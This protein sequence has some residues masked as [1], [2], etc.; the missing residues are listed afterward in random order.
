MNDQ[1]YFFPINRP[2]EKAFSQSK[3]NPAKLPSTHIN[4]KKIISNYDEGPSIKEKSDFSLYSFTTNNE[5]PQKPSVKK[6]L[7]EKNHSPSFETTNRNEF[8]K[9]EIRVKIKAVKE[10]YYSLSGKCSEITKSIESL[11]KKARD[12]K[13]HNGK[14]KIEENVELKAKMKSMENEIRTWKKKFE[15]TEKQNFHEI[16]QMKLLFRNSFIS[17]ESDI[18]EEKSAKEKDETK[19]SIISELKEKI[20][21]MIKKNMELNKMLNRL[22]DELGFLKI[23]SQAA[24][25]D[26]LSKILMKIKKERAET[27]KGYLN[28]LDS[29]QR[30]IKDLRLENENKPMSL[31]SAIF[32][33]EKNQKSQ[34]EGETKRLVLLENKN[35]ELENELEN[36]KLLYWNL[37]K[38]MQ[39]DSLM[40]GDV[41]FTEQ[42]LENMVYQTKKENFMKEEELKGKVKSLERQKESLQKKTIPKEFNLTKPSTAYR[43]LKK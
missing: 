26:F 5:L 8:L 33:N 17:S 22:L 21:V 37:E 24:R 7:F 40:G 10:N 20:E 4:S 9:A 1:V 34:D 15:D 43:F 2:N 28:K 14:A 41:K 25:E 36:L 19:K 23:E 13:N 11:E 42:H 30:E 35:K 27:E 32:F 18:P 31:E 29:L 38:K 12:E 39:Y 6:N 16:A 3:N